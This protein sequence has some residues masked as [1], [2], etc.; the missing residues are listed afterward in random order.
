MLLKKKYLT[1][2]YLSKHLIKIY[3]KLCLEINILFEIILTSKLSNA[4]KSKM[5]E[6][7]QEIIVDILFII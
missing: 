6:K 3:K 2:K 5:L 1:K 4:I 7:R